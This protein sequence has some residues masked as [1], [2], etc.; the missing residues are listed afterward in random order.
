M[1]DF[2]SLPDPDAAWAAVLQ[3]NRAW[4]GRFVTG[5][6]TTGIYCRPSCAARHPARCNVRFFVD[7]A[8]ARLAGL[9]AC[10]RCRPDDI[11]RDE[12]AVAQAL[13]LLVDEDPPR[14][15]A[16]AAAVGYAPDHFGRLFKSAVG[17]T[18][19][20]YMRA[21]RRGRAEEALSS[22]P[23]VTDAVY[24]AGYS[25][26]SRFYAE[27]GAR[28]GMTP[29]AWRK[30]GA[31]VTIRW[32]MAD[33]T[34]GRMLLAATDKGICRLSFDE[35]EAELRARFPKAQIAPGG[36]AMAS[37][38]AGAVAAVERPAMAAALP[39]DV[40]GTVFQEAVWRE[41][42]RIPAGETLSYTELATRAGNAGAVRA[43]GSACGANPV[44]VLI[45]CHRA[46]RQDGSLGGYAYGLERKKDLLRREKD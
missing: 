28:L 45:P 25:A 20:Q 42:Q 34:L 46:L 5:V 31:G 23:R 8:E 38:L 18:P 37:L 16:L 3:R 4:D 27:D 21:L 13:D 19:A 17:L 30:G 7:G 35:G 44:A 26:P 29:S 12:A 39:L 1:T 11:G 24:E 6:L 33:T 36:T 10:L 43:T 41:L 9:R 22:A 40:Q 15:A 32:A 2:D 14:L